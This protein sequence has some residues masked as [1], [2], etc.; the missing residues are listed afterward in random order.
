MDAMQVSDWIQ[1]VAAAVTAVGVVVA[2][3]TYLGRLRKRR[4][5]R[6]AK[7]HQIVKQLGSLV[8]AWQTLQRMSDPEV[9]REQ[10]KSAKTEVTATLDHAFRDLEKL[11]RIPNSVYCYLNLLEGL[12]FSIRHLILPMSSWVRNLDNG[13]ESDVDWLKGAMNGD[14]DVI[15]DFV[16]QD[17]DFDRL[18]SSFWSELADPSL[19]SSALNSMPLSPPK[20]VIENARSRW[21]SLPQRHNPRLSAL[22]WYKITAEHSLALFLRGNFS[23]PK[24]AGLPRSEKYC[25]SAFNVW[26]KLCEELQCQALKYT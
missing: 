14:L 23:D 18:D 6:A 16:L 4:V 20:E 2:V 11:I 12:S 19:F 26:A 15:K 13:S 3:L 24:I 5:R 25:L 7:I 1:A 17:D 8:A 9:S 10:F 22:L 21:I